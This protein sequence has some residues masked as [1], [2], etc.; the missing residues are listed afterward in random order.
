MVHVA[1]EMQRPRFTVPLLIGGATTSP[2]HTSGRL[3]PQYEGAAAFVKD[4]AR[5]VGVCQLLV[6][7]GR[8]GELRARVK[9]EHATRR[10]QHKGKKAKAPQVSLARAR[11]NKHH[12]DWAAYRPPTPRMLGLK[13]FEDYPLEELTR[14]IDWMPFF[15][16]WEFT[17]K[18]PD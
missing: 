7:A 15:N 17:G 13:S 10:E 18:F 6:T 12:I 11:A 4:A 16:A 14:F 9:Q 1:R 3:D 2:A 8:R 5:S